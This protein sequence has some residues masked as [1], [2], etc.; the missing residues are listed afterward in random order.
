MNNL[1]SD[2][3]DACIH[4]G[5]L[6]TAHDILDDFERMNNFP[7]PDSYASLVTGYRKSNKN[8][9][10]E[11]LLREMKKN[12]ILL[13]E[14]TSTSSRRSDLIAYLAQEMR[15]GYKDCS[16]HKFNSSIY[17]F[18]K[19]KMIDDALKTYKSMQRIKVYPT[20]AT[21]IY[22]VVGYSSLEMYREVTHLWGDIWRSCDNGNLS[23]N[24][25]LYEVL[26]LSFLKGG[27]FERVMEIIGCMKKRGMC[28]DKCLYRSEFLKLHKGLY[29]KLKA[30]NAR[31]EAQ[32]KRIE[33]VKAFRQWAGIN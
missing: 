27:Y 15:E 11:A 26:V 2:V 5:W 33:H 17:F 10:A 20:A 4:V 31:N 23:V 14:K 3:V 22:M 28:P 12:G 29:S 16:V 21:Y 6:E 32:S 8:R 13:S 30:S 25:D 18:M 19:A 24:I 9:E 7:N 1:S